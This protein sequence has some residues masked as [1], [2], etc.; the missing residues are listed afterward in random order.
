MALY[1]KAAD[2]FRGFLAADHSWQGGKWRARL[3]QCPDFKKSGKRFIPNPFRFIS[4]LARRPPA[5][6]AN[7]AVF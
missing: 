1:F 7:S 6:F 4:R 2:F 3:R 5:L